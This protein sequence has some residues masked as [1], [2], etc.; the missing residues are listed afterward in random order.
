[1]PV[2][3]QKQMTFF[4]PRITV[5]DDIR[6]AR[7]PVIHNFEHDLESIFWVFLWFLARRIEPV[8]SQ[9]PQ[10]CEW[11][12]ER[13]FQDS[14]E[15]S[16]AREAALKGQELYRRLS[17]HWEHWEHASLSDDFRQA[18]AEIVALTGRAL[19]N[20]YRDRGERF[21]DP[22]T[23]CT[24]FAKV[25]EAIQVSGKYLN[26]SLLVFETKSFE[27]ASGTKRKSAGEEREGKKRSRCD[28]TYAPNECEMEDD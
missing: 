13:V 22:T 25:E 7:L 18:L 10:E 24:L 11:W 4:E 1:M 17:K 28:E 9:C 14:T 6:R 8:R 21:D 12:W 20:G 3:I 15:A 23:Y 19:F 5:I 26:P 2:E 27:T 16:G